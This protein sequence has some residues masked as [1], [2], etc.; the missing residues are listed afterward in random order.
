[1]ATAILKLEEVWEDVQSVRAAPPDHSPPSNGDD[2]PLARLNATSADYARSVDEYLRR[3]EHIADAKERWKSLKVARV[4]LDAWIRNQSESNKIF[5]EK[6]ED[7]IKKTDKL[8]SDF[9]RLGRT[10]DVIATRRIQAGAKESLAI[11]AKLLR[12]LIKLRARLETNF[13]EV[14]RALP[15][16]EKTRQPLKPRQ[17]DIPFDAA[18]NDVMACTSVTREY[19]AR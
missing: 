17:S 15:P 5:T 14:D 11:S 16:E 1:M 2:P 3:L 6:I 12:D 7:R 8:I 10:Q 9:R 18:L 13:Q 19:L 4:T